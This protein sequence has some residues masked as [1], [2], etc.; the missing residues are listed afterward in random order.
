MS[1]EANPQAN[2]IE[3]RGVARL[4][5]LPNLVLFPGAMQPLHI[6]EPRYRD[7][8]AEAVATDQLIAVALLE[9]GWENEYDGR[10]PVHPAICLGRIATYHRLPDGRYNL[11]LQGVAR[12]QIL[13]EL[14]PS[15][16]FREARAELIVET[17][18]DA[19]TEQALAAQ[20]IAAISTSL[21]GGEAAQEH[22][23]KLLDA[24]ASLSAL[25]DLVAF[26]ADLPLD[27]KIEL[28]GEADVAARAGRILEWLSSAGARAS[29]I[30]FPP[31][32]S[33]N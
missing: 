26:A 4:F 12:A 20:L 25:T 10:P 17:Q 15:K 11:L 28:L 31:P 32:F 2:A 5:P 19:K 14:S 16:S 22:R 18:P 21:G 13:A 3:F 24:K 30:G 6:F 9:P 27:A 29:R 33:H 7:L 1:G 23:R 8:M